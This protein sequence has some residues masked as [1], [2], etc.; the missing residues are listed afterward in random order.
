MIFPSLLNE[1]VLLHVLLEFHKL[2][3][4]QLY[5]NHKDEHNTSIIN[6]TN[7]KKLHAH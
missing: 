1:K 5:A 2:P 3:E 7:D 6:V 4:Y